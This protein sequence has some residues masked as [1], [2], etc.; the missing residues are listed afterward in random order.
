M[1]AP[2]VLVAD[3]SATIRAVVRRTL[4]SIGL[5]VICVSDGLEAVERLREEPPDLA[6]LDINM[7]GLDGYAVCSQLHSM[8]PSWARVPIIFLTSDRSNALQ[9]LGQKLGAFLP[10]PVRPEQLIATVRQFVTFPE[11]CVQSSL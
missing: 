11:Q 5:N 2:K 9:L 4:E 3:D 6:I 8:G 10:K 1:A 7:P